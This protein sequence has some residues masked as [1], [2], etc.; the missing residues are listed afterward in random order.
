MKF[1]NLVKLKGAKPKL[2]E[3]IRGLGLEWF[4]ADGEA[5]VEVEAPKLGLT[6]ELEVAAALGA[7]VLKLREELLRSGHP[8]APVFDLLVKLSHPLETTIEL[9][10]LYCC[11]PSIEREV[12]RP[13]QVNLVSHKKAIEVQV[14][15][16]NSEISLNLPVF[17]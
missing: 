15:G 10:R 7:T 5:D 1:H 11:W 12:G 2:L 14:K 3:R 17:E 13:L 16:R 8:L 9:V 4:V 6:P